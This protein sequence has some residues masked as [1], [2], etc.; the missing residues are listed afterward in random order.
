MR[1]FQAAH[2]P[3][4]TVP[5]GSPLT[6]VAELMADE[7]LR[8]VVVVDED[9][10]PVGIVT[11][12]DLVVRGLARGRRA[13]AP[14]EVVMTPGVVTAEASAPARAVHRLLREHRIR[15]V[16]LM[17]GGRMVG[18]V[19]RDDLVDEAT[20]ELVAGLRHCPH[21]DGEWLRPVETRSSTNFVCLH[22]RSCWTISGG[23]FVAVE[24]RTCP[25]CPEHN[26]CRQPL[27]DYGL[28]ITR[29]PSASQPGS[30]P[31]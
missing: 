1:A 23:T 17:E 2:R 10:L 28:D 20:A 12:R 4:R 24:T 30:R 29:L 16:P 26:F 22:C 8:A 7:S 13:T 15:Q 25:G 18:M 3:L 31:W 5:A 27:I 6:D 11:E 19:E 21:C 14:V 9:G